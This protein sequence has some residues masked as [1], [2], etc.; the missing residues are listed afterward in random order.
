MPKVHPSPLY[1]VVVGL[2]ASLVLTRFVAT[3]LYG[4]AAT[5]ILT[6][7]AV[8]MSKLPRIAAWE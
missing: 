8:T 2:L 4:I 3:L 1:G 5:D 7:A 6:F